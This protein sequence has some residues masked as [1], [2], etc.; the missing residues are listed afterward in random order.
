MIRIGLLTAT[1]A[2]LMAG[3]AFAFHCPNDMA[4]IDAAL[5]KAQLSDTNK[6]KVMELRTSGEQQHKAGDHASAVKT[7]A[8]A[9][10]I[11]GL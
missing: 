2:M 6:A 8:Q 7:L 3:P 11:L 5:P 4:A 9:M 1:L 10:K